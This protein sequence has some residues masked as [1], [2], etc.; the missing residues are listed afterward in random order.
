[1]FYFKIVFLK[2]IWSTK[3]VVDVLTYVVR[4]VE[5]LLYQTRLSKKKFIL[6]FKQTNNNF[7]VEETFL[8]INL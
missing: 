4:V 8:V 3:L 6:S 7:F 1:M 2:I 5:F